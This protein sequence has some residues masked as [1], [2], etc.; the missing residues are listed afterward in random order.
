M[1]PCNPASLQRE[2]IVA[3]GDARAAHGDGV[4]RRSAGETFQ[5]A[6]L[7]FGGRQEAPVG[8]QIGRER[9]IDRARHVAGHRIQGFDRAGEALRGACIHQQTASILERLDELGGV[10][11]GLILESR[12]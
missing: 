4:A 3:G 5:P 9:M 11:H 8:A 2:Q 7:E 6:A 1:A 12:V 10:E